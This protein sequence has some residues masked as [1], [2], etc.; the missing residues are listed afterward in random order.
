[1]Y[2]KGARVVT[3]ALSVLMV[4]MMPALPIAAE[5]YIEY[6]RY[7]E[8]E[9]YEEYGLIK[10]MNTGVNMATLSA[11]QSGNGWTT[12][13]TV[14]TLTG[15][16]SAAPIVITGTVSNGRR[17]EVQ[18]GAA[19][20]I[21]LNGV[22]VTGLDELQS[23]LLLNSGAELTLTLQGVNT[24][25]AG[26]RGA[27][28]EVSYGTALTVGGTGSLTVRG[29]MQSAGIGGSVGQS[30]GTIT[31]NSGTVTAVG[32]N[33]GAG[34][35][36]G[37]SLNTWSPLNAGNITINGGTITAT[38][39][40][41]GAGIGGG[42]NG[43]DGFITIT[44]GF[45]EATGGAGGA[46]I[47][48]GAVGGSNNIS[49][50]TINISGGTVI[51]SSATTGHGA[52][53]G[54]GNSGGNGN[55]SGGNITIS[56][57]ANVTAQ[58]DSGNG[59]GI[60]GGGGSSGNG[61]DGGNITISGNAIVN[62][63]GGRG[64]AVGS[65]GFGGAGIG[66][67]SSGAAA[68]VT[69]SGGTVNATGRGR[70][71]GIDDPDIDFTG[72]PNPNITMSGLYLVTFNPNG[73]EGTMLP[74]T[75]TV[76]SDF[77][78]PANTFTREYYT[79]AGWNT[80]AGG[81]GTAYSDAATISDIQE[82]I[83]LFAQWTGTAITIPPTNG[84]GNEGSAVVSISTAFAN[85]DDSNVQVHVRITNNHG[86][87]SML[88]R[89][90]FPRELTLTGYSLASSDLYQNFKAP[91]DFAALG[92]YVYMGWAG[93]TEN[94]TR[95]GTL[96][97]LIFSV[98]ADAPSVAT[99]PV[100]ATFADYAE[101]D[102][103]ISDGAVRVWPV[104]R[105]D[106]GGAGRVTSASATILARHIVGHNVAIDLRAADVNCDGVVNTDDLIRLSRTLVGHFHTL[107]PCDPC[108]NC[109]SCGHLRLDPTP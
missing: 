39:G 12:N 67:S 105:G 65:G 104:I 9:N 89:F 63:Q 31:I 80:N 15:N 68:N 42:S 4:F 93:R 70:A 52:G 57:D 61:G 82:S 46:G 18:S 60:G 29:G 101:L 37:L 33:G 40:S 32:G 96:F 20:F 24:L 47:G 45:V 23:P 99:F 48:G 56:G 66:G 86:F 36:S 34:I 19:A 41:S 62:A 21:T 87:A 28:I 6:E 50:G 98:C 71:P 8:Y 59:S 14:L 92:N 7:E 108:G 78:I 55:G 64:S 53:I 38:G 106:V 25:T 16:T 90:E 100:T 22:S 76:G 75:A 94:I 95:E 54:G 10:P 91:Y 26:E 103:H 97:T 43:G 35:G 107:C 85:P 3:T 17:I 88:M 2:K 58:S 81:D 5:T 77:V 11:G 72:N 13:G 102:M 30:A 44:G 79:F 69:I 83:M 84:N 1:M 74:R 51:A 109:D 49:G 27:G 73:G